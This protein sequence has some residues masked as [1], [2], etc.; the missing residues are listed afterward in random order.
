MVR[1]NHRIVD[2]PEDRNVPL[3]IRAEARAI[4]VETLPP[5]SKAKYLKRYNDYKTWC[6][7]RDTD[8]LSEESLLVYLRKSR[9]VDENAASMLRSVYSMIKACVKV[10]HNF[11]IG[12]YAHVNSYLSN[13]SRRHIPKNGLI[14]TSENMSQFVLEAPDIEYFLIKVISIIGVMGCCRKTAGD[15]TIG[16]VPKKVAEYLGLSQPERYTSH[17]IRRSSAT[18]YAETGCNDVELMRHGRWQ[19]LKCAS[20]YVEDT[21]F[22]KHK[23]SHLIT[24]AILPSHYPTNALLPPQHISNAISPPQHISNAIL[25]HQH[26]TSIV[27]YNFNNQHLH[28]DKQNLTPRTRQPSGTARNSNAIATSSRR[29]LVSSQVSR[30]VPLFNRRLPSVSNRQLS[31]C[32]KQLTRCTN[33]TVTPGLLTSSTVSPDVSHSDEV[34]SSNLLP[35]IP[36]NTTSM[37]SDSESSFEETHADSASGSGL[38]VNDNALRQPNSSSKEVQQFSTLSSHTDSSQSSSLNVEV[39]SDFTDLLNVT[40]DEES[41]APDEEVDRNF[42]DPQGVDVHAVSMPHTYTSVQSHDDSGVGSYEGMMARKSP[43]NKTP[44]ISE[45]VYK[46]LSEVF[47]YAL[48]QVVSPEQ[49]HQSEN[50]QH[51]EAQHENEHENEQQREQSHEPVQQPQRSLDHSGFTQQSHFGEEQQSPSNAGSSRSHTRKLVASPGVS[52]KQSFSGPTTFPP[53]AQPSVLFND[54]VNSPSQ[55]RAPSVVSEFGYSNNSYNEENEF[56]FGPNIFKIHNRGTINIHFHTH[57][58]N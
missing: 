57:S 27:Q 28:M 33:S 36:S 6:Q 34:S 48:H 55:P 12:V 18:A 32:S 38:S 51:Q 43:S 2:R 15:T 5:V 54:P 35:I 14:L 26:Q 47:G 16:S 11:D 58:R 30:S 29:D 21:K 3:D 10:H 39:Q 37:L 4:Q 46:N 53:A 45:G 23:V 8:L 41:I 19:S 44:D 1:R 22:G 52:Q 50:D 31:Q 9:V 25:P 40:S 49:D 42:G 7:G 24:K 56:R 17:S 20:G 13:L